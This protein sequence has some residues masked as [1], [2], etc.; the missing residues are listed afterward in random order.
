MPGQ[1]SAKEGTIW[2]GGS[3]AAW[4]SNEERQHLRSPAYTASAG[5]MVG[6]ERDVEGPI[7]PAPAHR[8]TTLILA[9]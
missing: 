2:S 3:D 8:A 9:L 1:V 4:T 5:C 6:H 7:D